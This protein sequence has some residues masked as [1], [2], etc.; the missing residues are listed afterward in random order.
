MT[1]LKDETLNIMIAGRDTTT[2]VLTCAL[3]ALATHPRV[4]AR[5]RA[6]VLARV[7]PARA[8]TPDDVRAMHFLRAV[9]NEVLRLWPPVPFNERTSVGEVLLSAPKGDV[10]RRP[11]YVPPGTACVLALFRS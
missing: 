9:V 10:D 8:P 6:E 1:I 2:S 4:L 11:Y 7:G 3:Y 5:L